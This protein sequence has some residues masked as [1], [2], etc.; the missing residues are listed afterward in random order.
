MFVA[1]P[2][3]LTGRVDNESWP[4]VSSTRLES[5]CVSPPRRGGGGR[6]IVANGARFYDPLG[7]HYNQGASPQKMVDFYFLSSNSNSMENELASL[8]LSH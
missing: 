2:T 7:S 5:V 4:S 6:W 1:T 3:E 8:P